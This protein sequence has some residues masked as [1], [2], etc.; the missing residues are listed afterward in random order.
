M[1]FLKQIFLYKGVALLTR[2][3]TRQDCID[4]SSRFL[5]SHILMI[6]LIHIASLYSIFVAGAA[7]SDL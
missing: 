7:V 3:D 4:L 1:G 2:Y 5:P 6:H